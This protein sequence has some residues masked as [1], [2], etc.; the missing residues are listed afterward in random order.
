MVP[1]VRPRNSRPCERRYWAERNV[2]LTEE[3]PGAIRLL[4]PAANNFLAD[5]TKRA[6]GSFPRLRAAVRASAQTMVCKDRV[7]WHQDTWLRSVEKFYV[8]RQGNTY[9]SD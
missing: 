4:L 6:L 7:Y 2:S 9:E 3:T 1:W 5:F 8:V